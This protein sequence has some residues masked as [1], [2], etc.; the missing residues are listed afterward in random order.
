MHRGM[1]EFMK[2]YQPGTMLVKD[3]NGDKI[4]D[5]YSIF[6]RWKS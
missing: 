1:N 5:S 2:G 3:K 6:D 4:L